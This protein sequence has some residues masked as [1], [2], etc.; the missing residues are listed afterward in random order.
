MTSDGSVIRL[1][2]DRPN[3]MHA[4]MSAVVSVVHAITSSAAAWLASDHAVNRRMSRRAANA[5]S[6][7]RPMIAEIV[8]A[9][10]ENPAWARPI[11]GSRI[12]I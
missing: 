4:A 1:P 6:P 11:V 5:P 8:S 12:A 3:T 2:A 7:K 10:T 9:A